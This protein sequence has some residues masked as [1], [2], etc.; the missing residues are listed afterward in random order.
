M[1]KLHLVAQQDE[2]ARRCA[3]GHRVGEG[4]LACF[5]YIEVVERV[6]EFGAGEAPCGAADDEWSLGDGSGGVLRLDMRRAPADDEWIIGVAAD[7]HERWMRI[8][9]I[10]A[11]GDARHEVDDHLVAIGNDAHALAVGDEG[12]DHLRGGG[13]LAGAGRALNAECGVVETAYR[14][15]RVL[16]G[17]AVGEA[18]GASLEEIAQGGVAIGVGRPTRGK[19]QH[20]LAKRL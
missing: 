10:A 7:L 4:E 5:L 9:F 18:R 8:D 11:L 15:D 16:C 12:E 20:R 2:I 6:L 13:G 17:A 1:G 14:V 3:D 19:A